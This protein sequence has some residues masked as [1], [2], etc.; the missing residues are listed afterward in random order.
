[1][2]RGRRLHLG[3]SRGG[4]HPSEEGSAIGREGQRREERAC[5]REERRRREREEGVPSGS[6]HDLGAPCCIG[7]TLGW[8]RQRWIAV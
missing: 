2:A 3:A 5:R 8:K 4:W 6:A 7:R 1:M